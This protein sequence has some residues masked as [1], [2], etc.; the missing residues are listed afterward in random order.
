MVKS[1]KIRIVRPKEI[2]YSIVPQS[3][4]KKKSPEKLHDFKKDL[5]NIKK[6]QK[7]GRQR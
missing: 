3:L 7:K 5:K 4:K 2:A 1:S 6:R